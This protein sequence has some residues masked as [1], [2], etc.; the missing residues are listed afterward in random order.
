MIGIQSALK[1]EIE[2]IRERMTGTRMECGGG[3]EFA[4]GNIGGTQLVTAAG[5]VGTARAATCAQALIDLYHVE[6]I[7][8]CGVAGR[9]NSRLK[10][11]DII[12][13]REVLQ[14]DHGVHG[15]RIQADETLVRVTQEACANTVGDTSYVTGTVLTFDRA[16]LTRKKRTQLLKAYGADCV[17]MEGAAV[18]GVCAAN[19][20]PFVVL[21]AISDRAGF[22]ALL[23]LRRNLRAS[24]RR[25]QEVVLELLSLLAE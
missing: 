19:D 15:N 7:I 2:L 25:V 17:E 5:G 6:S 13:S 18:G 4:V 14:C 1:V 3:L 22:L 23:E 24:S 12:I 10:V 16:V 8:F 21:R 20:V 11:G 9:L